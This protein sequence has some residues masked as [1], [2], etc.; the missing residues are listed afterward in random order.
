MSLTEFFAAVEDSEAYVCVS[1]EI[2]DQAN[3]SPRRVRRDAT[4]GR[5]LIRGGAPST[6]C[7]NFLGGGRAP[8]SDA[9]SVLRLI[10]AIPSSHGG[11]G[12]AKERGGGAGQG[13]G[14]RDTPLAK[15][16]GGGAGGDG[17][18]SS[19]PTSV[20]K[21]AKADTTLT[22]HRPSLGMPVRI[23]GQ[24]PRQLAMLPALWG[25]Q[26]GRRCGPGCFGR[27]LGRGQ[28]KPVAAAPGDALRGGSAQ[29]EEELR[30]GQACPNGQS[31]S[32]A[33]AVGPRIQGTKAG[34]S[35][36]GG[37]RQTPSLEFRRAKQGGG[38]GRNMCGLLASA[39]AGCEIH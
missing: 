30:W 34:G 12:G 1:V 4:S 10:A 7:C 37:R 16:S 6:L 19:G 22:R 28:A 3:I 20:G 21:G 32:P 14:G 13:R 38:A 18:A 11:G 29:A 24:L 27:W 17:K 15:T 35:A 25:A 2:L 5:L 31:A 26:G 36:P 33:R 9:T 23:R 8:S 39:P